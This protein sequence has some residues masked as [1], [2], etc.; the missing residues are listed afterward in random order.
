MFAS[1]ASIGVMGLGDAAS[2]P[3][4]EQLQ[5]VVDPT[6]PCQNPIASLPVSTVP[7]GG[8][9]ASQILFG[10][11]ASV[12]TAAQIMAG[13]SPTVTPAIPGLISSATASATPVVSNTVIF[14]A[15]GIGILFFIVMASK[16]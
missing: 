9:T 5:G 16:R 13:A 11:P 15:A 12:P 2:C 8:P 4:I 14:A 6:D 1:R 7:S 3:S 10:T